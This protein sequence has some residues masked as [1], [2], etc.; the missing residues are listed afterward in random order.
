MTGEV[1]GLEIHS[2]R[3]NKTC[4]W[5]RHEGHEGGGGI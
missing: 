5:T 1:D 2:E 3:T 4:S